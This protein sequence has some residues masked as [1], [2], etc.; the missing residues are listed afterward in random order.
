MALSS[1]ESMGCCHNKFLFLNT[2]SLNTPTHNRAAL[3]ILLFHN[4][5]LRSIICSHSLVVL[6]VPSGYKK[7]LLLSSFLLSASL[8]VVVILLHWVCC[9][10]YILSVVIS[11]FWSTFSPCIVTSASL[12]SITTLNH[13]MQALTSPIMHHLIHKL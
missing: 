7:L 6:Y 5:H 3:Y 12:I 9:C 1:P 8:T 2:R 13:D 11:L 10:T 4:P